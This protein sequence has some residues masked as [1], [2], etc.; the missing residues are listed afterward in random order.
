MLSTH[1]F[2]SVESNEE[3]VLRTYS[4]VWKYEKKIYSIQGL[5]LWFPVVVKEIPFFAASIIITILAVKI[6]P[7]YSKL[8]FV[9]KFIAVPFGLMKFFT[10]IKLDGKLPHKFIFDYLVFLIMPK[11]YARFQALDESKFLKFTTP[12]LFRK[13]IVINKTDEIVKKR[14]KGCDN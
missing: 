2:M 10:S 3:I 9:I 8:H 6:I 12:I 7:F 13:Q 14:I 5:K 11:K 4:S 1:Y